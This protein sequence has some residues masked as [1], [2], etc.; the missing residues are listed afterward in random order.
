[1]IY[2][3]LHNLETCKNCKGLYNDFT[4]FV[5][6]LYTLAKKKDWYD[7]QSFSFILLHNL[8]F[9]DAGEEC[10]AC[11][12]QMDL[13]GGVYEAHGEDFSFEPLCLPVHSAGS[14][15]LEEHKQKRPALLRGVWSGKRPPNRISYSV[16]NQCFIRKR[17]CRGVK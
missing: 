4:L 3:C 7:G 2:S 5:K 13:S 16:Y 6:G 15:H 10:D 1:M 8:I 9:I 17:T 14:I 11:L 12:F